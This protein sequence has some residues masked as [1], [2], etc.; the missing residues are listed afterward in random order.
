MGRPEERGRRARGA[1]LRGS[2]VPTVRDRELNEAT[3]PGVAR[4]QPTK[5]AQ[6]YTTGHHRTTAPP[7]AGNR[8]VHDRTLLIDVG[9]PGSRPQTRD[10]AAAVWDGKVAPMLVRLSRG[11][12]WRPQ[13]GA[14][15]GRHLQRLPAEPAVATVAGNAAPVVT[16]ARVA[17]VVPA[18]RGAGD[19]APAPLLLRREYRT[20]PKTI[21]TTTT[22]AIAKDDPTMDPP[23]AGSPDSGISLPVSAAALQPWIQRGELDHRGPPEHECR[24]VGVVY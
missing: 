1:R 4:P 11:K 19:S 17:A 18:A 20:M 23:R 9:L 22:D 8:T 15:R 24:F 21:T 12:P 16:V 6:P 7:F 13:P 14:I 10:V 5:L 2:P 3:Q